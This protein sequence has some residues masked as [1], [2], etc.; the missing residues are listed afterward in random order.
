MEF[1][2][3]D[4]ELRILAVMMEKETLTPELYPMTV[5]YIKTAA[6]QKS[7]RFPVMDLDE[8][9]ISQG[10]SHLRNKGLVMLRGDASSRAQ[11]FEHLFSSSLKLNE[12]EAVV[13]CLLMLRGPQTAGELKQ[14]SGRLFEFQSV[15]EVDDVLNTLAQ[16]TPGALV[17][18]LSKAPGQKECRYIHLLYVE[19]PLEPQNSAESATSINQ[20]NESFATPEN[21]EETDGLREKVEQLEEE[22]TRLRREF[23]E[24]KSQF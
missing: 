15:V 12:K 1:K 19:P 11:K 4:T 17:K 18:Q 3:T 9:E 6:N 22:L 7:S 21:K 16:R 13:M 14:R 2:L 20:K 5:N 23:E 24:F 10:L 8:G